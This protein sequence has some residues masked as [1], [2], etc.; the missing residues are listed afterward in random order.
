MNFILFLIL[1]SFNALKLDKFV[2]RFSFT[3]TSKNISSF[4]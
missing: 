3:N 2:L 4:T 1:F